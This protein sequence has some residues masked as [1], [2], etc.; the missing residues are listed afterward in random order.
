MR[1]TRSPIRSFVVW[2]YG[3]L[4]E[5]YPPRFRHEFGAEIRDIFWDVILE[6]EGHGGFWLLK[7][8]LRELI[9]LAISISLECWHE[10]RSRK[11]QEMASQDQFHNDESGAG[12]SGPALQPVRAPNLAWIVSWTLLTT[13]AIPAALVAMAPLAVAFMWLFNLGVSA[14]FWPA[15]RYSTLEPLGFI[16]AITLVLASVQWYLLRRLLPRAWL[17]F[18]ATVAGLLLYS[19]FAWIVVATVSLQSWDPYWIMAAVLLPVGLALGLA[20]WIYLRRFLPNATW[21]IL[22]DVLAA[23]SILSAGR[24]F[25]SLAELAVLALPGAISGVGLWLL[26]S[27]SHSKIQPEVRSEASQEKPL[28]FPRLAWVGLGLLV[29]VPLFFG[30]IWAYAA[31]Q[32]ALAKDR[33][34]YATPEEGVIKM[35]SQGWGGAKVVRIEN[36]WA[37]P[38]SRNAQPHVWF[39]GA[40][41]YLDR[42]PQGGRWDHY[43]SGSFYLRVREGWVH[44]SEGAFPEFIGWVMELYNMEGVRK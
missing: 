20:Q 31:S 42:V 33:G 10:L 40:E 27:Q 29:L 9:A 12:F 15:I 1:Q 30:C 32:L 24:S 44:V 38:N 34:I 23:G 2:L 18:V 41:V 3:C 26:L 4:L 28:R 17:W 7:T 14:G 43:S 25:T 16:I 5:L 22:I 11:E 6:A 8:S 13:A 36:V 39:G 21:I 19:A 37:E 35:N